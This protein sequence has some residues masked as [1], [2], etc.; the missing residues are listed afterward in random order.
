MMPGEELVVLHEGV[1]VCQW[2][3]LHRPRKCLV[4]VDPQNA[5]VELALAVLTKL[6]VGHPL[7]DLGW[8]G[9]PLALK[10]LVYKG[11]DCDQ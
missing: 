3:G 1:A 5:L 4:A 7:D 2:Q 11:T 9:E 10:Y 6:I 8:V